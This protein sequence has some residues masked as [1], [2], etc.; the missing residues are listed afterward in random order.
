MFNSQ[1][2]SNK[3]DESF[4]SSNTA[5]SPVN[6]L[7]PYQP[8]L[9]H[10]QQQQQQQHQH[11]QQDFQL[12]QFQMSSNT[13]TPSPL[14]SIANLNQSIGHQ[15][16]NDRYPH[17]SKEQVLAHS[18]TASST[19]PQDFYYHYYKYYNHSNNFNNNFISNNANSNGYLSGSYNGY[20]QFD[21]MTPQSLHS[22]V[23]TP[24]LYTRNT[25]RNNSLDSSCNLDPFTSS[26]SSNSSAYLSPQ[27]SFHESLNQYT[28]N[29][30]INTIN[31]SNN[32]T[33]SNM[34]NIS[35]ANNSNND[36]IASY[37]NQINF[38]F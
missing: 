3:F 25:E 38:E 37:T 18:L 9:V 33:N 2:A 27:S 30:H 6:F 13:K 5:D 24:S 23:G 19:Y 32:N 4:A 1:T 31:N 14:E 8:S 26:S 21:P 17:L 35:Q 29:H 22:A 20:N 28:S 12:Q 10:L 16:I 11:N 15:L 36:L 7:D 34:T